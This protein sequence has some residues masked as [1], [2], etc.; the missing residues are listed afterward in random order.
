MDSCYFY[1]TAKQ[2]ISR[3]KNMSFDHSH[4]CRQHRRCTCSTC[5]PFAERRNTPFSPNRCDDEC[6]HHHGSKRRE[7]CCP[8][9]TGATGATG[10]TGGTGGTGSTGAT[11]IQ[12]ATGIPGSFAGIG[13]TGVTGAT[14]TPGGTGATGATGLTGGTGGTGG[15]GATGATGI[16]IQGGTGATG[17]V[18][19]SGTGG[20]FIPFS[21]GPIVN[22]TV[23]ASPPTV[24]GFGSNQVLTPVSSPVQFGQF[25]F[26]IPRAGT[27]DRL[28]AS[29][30]VHFAPNTA[31]VAWTYIFTVFRSPS[32]AVQN[33]TIPYT[34]TG[35]VATVPLPATTTTTFPTGQFVSSSGLALGSVTVAMGDRIVLLLTSD[36]PGTPPAIDQISFSAGLFYN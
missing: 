30:D 13:A 15:T 11:G 20:G 33:P 28:E 16:G 23:I 36:Q 24:M 9:A 3:R 18:G 26:A 29:V 5:D 22:A 12:G 4:G 1:P 21:S 27:L 10:L 31:Q 35:I 8:G 19:P 17:A 34:S 14:G 25:A 7:N 2:E 32:P 6:D